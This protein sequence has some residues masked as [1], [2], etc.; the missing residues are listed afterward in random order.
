M[1]EKWF[2]R[3]VQVTTIALTMAAICQELEK[4]AA[5][6]KWYGKVGFVPYDF[7]FPT[8]ER[9][10]DTYWNVYDSRIF[11]SEAFGV[12]WTINFY[13]LLERLRLIGQAA[14]SEENFLMPTKSIKEVLEH[15]QQQIEAP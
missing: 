8:A 14:T 5:E 3:I 13:A 1:N 15:S 2:L 12:G 11:T 4:P 9:L 6:R 7:R 10:K